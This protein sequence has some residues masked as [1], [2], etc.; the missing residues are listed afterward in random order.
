M[1][2]T[3]RQEIG[4]NITSSNASQCPLRAGSGY[5]QAVRFQQKRA[6]DGRNS[7]TCEPA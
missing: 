4:N 7:L 3:R 6:L 2:S 5:Q 1:K